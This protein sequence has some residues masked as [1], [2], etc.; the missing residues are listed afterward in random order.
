[1]RLGNNTKTKFLII[2]N[3][4][5]D[6]IRNSFLEK[7]KKITG[8]YSVD[9][10]LQDGIVKKQQTFDAQKIDI[11]FA[12]QESSA[13]MQRFFLNYYQKLRN[14]EILKICENVKIF[15]KMEFSLRK[16]DNA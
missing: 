3:K 2:L 8:K 13:A 16:I 11:F 9:V 12:I 10:M 6:E 15:S 7:V 14:S 4:K 1:M 5:N